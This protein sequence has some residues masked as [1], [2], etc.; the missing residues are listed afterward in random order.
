MLIFHVSPPDCFRHIVHSVRNLTTKRLKSTQTLLHRLSS[1][2]VTHCF[3]RKIFEAEG[4]RGP[5]STLRSCQG[6]STLFDRH[7]L[8]GGA[9]GPHSLGTIGVM[10]EM[11]RWWGRRA[12]LPGCPPWGFHCHPQGAYLSPPALQ[13]VL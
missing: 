9:E 3:C 8:H 5:A 4:H 6:R 12:F 1:T 10:P 13:S 11:P 2:L 7:P